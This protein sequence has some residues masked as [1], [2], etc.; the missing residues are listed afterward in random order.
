[1]DIQNAIK[2]LIEITFAHGEYKEYKGCFCPIGY[3][4]KIMRANYIEASKAF[5]KEFNATH[6]STTW[7]ELGKIFHIS[8]KECK[9]YGATLDDGVIVADFTID[10]KDYI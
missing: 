2:Y 7:L 5:A 10:V 1:M 8:F 6:F 9:E 4:S 3:P